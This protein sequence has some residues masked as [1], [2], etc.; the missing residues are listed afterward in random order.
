M[1]RKEELETLTKEEKEL[2]KQWSISEGLLYYKDRL[3]IPYNEDL[4]TLIA[5]SCHDSKI[6]GHC[7]QE[8][9]LEIITRDFY[10]KSI[11]DWVND[12]VRSCTSCQQAQAPRHAPFGLLSS[13]QV[14][15]APWAS[16]SVDFITQLP[17]SAGYTQI[18]VIV[19]RFIKM[20]HLMELQENATAKEVAEAFLKEVWKLHGLQSE[21]ISDMDAKFVG[22]F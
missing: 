21:I 18:M 4:Q 3:F 20:A 17:N 5:K 14:P 8:K 22:E 7:G 15:Y 1:R 11:T 2:H 19:D 10:W 6:A 9:T 12:Y 13:L 16:R